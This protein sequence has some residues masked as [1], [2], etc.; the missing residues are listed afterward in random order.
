MWGEGARLALMV[1][2]LYSCIKKLTGQRFETKLTPNL[3][4]NKK[5]NDRVAGMD[6]PYFSF[7][8][9]WNT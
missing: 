3:K 5:W 4:K 9:D 6:H 8:K 2:L 1:G 7:L